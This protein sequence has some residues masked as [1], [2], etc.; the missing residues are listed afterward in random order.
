MRAQIWASALLIIGGVVL[1]SLIA[2]AV[3]YPDL[4]AGGTLTQAFPHLMKA[5]VNV[6]HRYLIPFRVALFEYNGG[7][8][9]DAWPTRDPIVDELNRL[10]VEVKG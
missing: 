8:V 7:I 1:G 4:K 10:G 2:L 6:E 9:V 3:A 5:E